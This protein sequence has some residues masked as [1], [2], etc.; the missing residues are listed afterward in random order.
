[1]FFLLFPAFLHHF[2]SNTLS[3]AE[4]SGRD[5]NPQVSSLE[6]QQKGDMEQDQRELHRLKTCARP[7]RTVIVQAQSGYATETPQ[8]VRQ[9]IAHFQGPSSLSEEDLMLSKYTKDP[10]P[11]LL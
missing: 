7:R 2:Q 5:K 11:P 10:R 9:L 4:K 8:H 3:R 6:Q 1:M